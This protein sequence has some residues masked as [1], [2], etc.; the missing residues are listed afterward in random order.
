MRCARPSDLHPNGRIAGLLARMRATPPAGSGGDGRRGMPL[1]VS[2]EPVF[3]VEA[4]TAGTCE[5]GDGGATA[6]R[7]PS[8]PSAFHLSLQ[9]FHR[10]FMSSWKAEQPR[11]ATGRAGLLMMT[12]WPTTRT[13]YKK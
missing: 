6:G 3:R 4:G 12:I 5:R 8:R 13:R 11:P 7:G 10:P 9:E 2:R 1:S